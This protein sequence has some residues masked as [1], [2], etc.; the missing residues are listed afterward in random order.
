MKRLIPIAAFV[1][2]CLFASAPSKAQ[3]SW[4]GN[5]LARC[6]AQWMQN[7]PFIG[8][9]VA[10]AECEAEWY[11]IYSDPDC[12]LE[13]EY[14][15]WFPTQV[16]EEGNTYEGSEGGTCVTCDPPKPD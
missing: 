12:N 3:N 10:E 4:E 8:A 1:V 14:D 9:G 16:E 5:F 13:C 11:F 7:L 6:E 15:S 2:V